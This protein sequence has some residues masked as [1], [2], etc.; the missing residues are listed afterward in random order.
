MMPCLTEGLEV[1]RPV[2]DRPFWER[3]GGEKDYVRAHG[4]KVALNDS[5][6][7][8]A[9]RGLGD[10]GFGDMYSQAF[11]MRYMVARP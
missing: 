5:A 11:P 10:R 9:S 7:V 6:S 1:L 4:E 2:P 3:L 8:M